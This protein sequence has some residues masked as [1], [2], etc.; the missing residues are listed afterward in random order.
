MSEQDTELRNRIGPAIQSADALI[1][2][3]GLD[4]A[5]AYNQLRKI[6]VTEMTM[7]NV[8]NN[9][10]LRVE[11]SGKKIIDVEEDDDDMTAWKSSLD[12]AY[13]NPTASDSINVPSPFPP[14]DA[15]NGGTN[16]TNEI[17]IITTATSTPSTITRRGLTYTAD[18]GPSMLER[19]A[20][21]SEKREINKIEIA[22]K[23]VNKILKSGKISAPNKSRAYF[24]I[25]DLP[26]KMQ[27][28]NIADYKKVRDYLLELQNPTNNNLLAKT[29]K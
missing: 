12:E 21:R 14:N 11:L 5:E 9:T 27:N 23:E 26:T 17:P 13:Q 22:L 29:K 4:Y 18:E 2:E 16:E 8:A 28:I 3:A 25:M 10:Q 7:S 6:M 20:E 1:K 24:Q 15:E 19:R